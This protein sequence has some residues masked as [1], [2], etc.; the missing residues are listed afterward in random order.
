MENNLCLNVADDEEETEVWKKTEQQVP[1][2]IN[3][4]HEKRRL[5]SL[6]WYRKISTRHAADRPF[7]NPPGR[8]ISFSREDNFFFSK[9]LSIFS[10]VLCTLFTGSSSFFRIGTSITESLDFVVTESIYRHRLSAVEPRWS[11]PTCSQVSRAR[12]VRSLYSIFSLPFLT[13]RQWQ[14]IKSWKKPMVSVRL[15]SNCLF[16]YNFFIHLIFQQN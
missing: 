8:W 7:D 4:S 9:P 3:E 2:F 15:N 6:P 16:L 5:S 14:L 10:S 11:L 1:N 13:V 12:L